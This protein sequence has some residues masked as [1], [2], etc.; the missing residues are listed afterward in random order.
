[1][2]QGAAHVQAHRPNGCVQAQPC[3]GG[4]G[5][6]VE[7]VVQACCPDVTCIHKDGCIQE[8][9]QGAT[10]LHVEFEQALTAGRT[11]AV[12]ERPQHGAGPATVGR[13]AARVK[14]LFYWYEAILASGRQEAA[15][16]PQ[17]EHEMAYGGVLAGIHPEPGEVVIP[18]EY[19]P[20][21]FGTHLYLKTGFRC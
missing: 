15:H 14:A 5:Q 17:G 11:A 9:E 10:Q 6:F 1:M 13:A 16:R 4:V 8:P 19:I 20:I 7:G 12:A 18:T 21:D 3:T 2:P